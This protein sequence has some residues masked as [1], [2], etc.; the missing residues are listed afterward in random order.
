MKN[1]RS[2]LSSL[3]LLACIL[4]GTSSALAQG[5]SL[6]TIR[7]RVTDP[8]GAAVQNASVKVTDLETN[9]TRELTTDDEGEYEATALKTGTYRVTVTGSGFTPKAIRVTLTGSEPVRAD[10]A[11]EIGGAVENVEVV[12]EA[13]IIQTESPTIAGTITNRQLVE[14]PRDSRDIY[15]FLFLNPNITQGAA[16]DSFKFIGAQSY[17]RPS[18]SD[19]QRSNGGAS[20]RPLPASRR[21][22]R[23]RANGSFQYFTLSTPAWPTRVQTSAGRGLPRLLFYNNRNSALAAWTIQDKINRA[24]F[25]PS[26]ARPDYPKPYFNLNEAGGSLNG[27]VP[28]LSKGK[29]FFMGAYER[30]WTVSPTLFAVRVGA[31]GAGVPGQRILEGDF[32]H[33]TDANKPNVPAAVLPL[34]TRR[35]WPTTRPGWGVRRFVT[36]PQ[37]C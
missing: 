2:F 19:G 33:L 11:L 7:G 12:S 30:R 31:T 35:S 36:I 32:S 5:T 17:A 20:A 6:G 1:M 23:Q 13:G 14:L 18:L 24:N 4:C 26:F 34:L 21:W 8:T 3:L 27:P 22:R 9:I 37:V 25:V 16:E 29:T 10:A 28:F 15:S